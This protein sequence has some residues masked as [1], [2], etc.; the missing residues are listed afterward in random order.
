VVLIDD[1]YQVHVI[2]SRLLPAA[3]EEL[4]RRGRR[5]LKVIPV[6]GAFRPVATPGT[7][8]RP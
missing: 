1:G 4:Y 8:A 3:V 7:V 6:F 5:F 2:D